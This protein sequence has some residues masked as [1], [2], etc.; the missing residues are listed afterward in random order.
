MPFK[1]AVYIA[2]TMALTGQPRAAG[3][4]LLHWCCGLRPSEAV[5]LASDNIL[6]TWANKVTAQCAMVML[7]PT[8]RTKSNRSRGIP[9]SFAEDPVGVLVADAFAASTP[10]GMRLSG[11]RSYQAYRTA[12]MKAIV[13]GG[14]SHHRW[15]PHSPRSGWA[16][17]KKL[18][19]WTAAEIQ[20]LGGWA[21]PV[22]AR[23]YIDMATIA[24]QSLSVPQVESTADWLLQD[25]RG[26]FP[27]WR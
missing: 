15:T 11:L 20:E 17:T 25:F 13:K 8:V 21:N 6:P 9:L 4:L 18:Q 5:Q 7:G 16:S 2:Y 26:R 1:V 12:F 24:L 14:L 10:A 23:G 27:W 3:V 19:G 22:T